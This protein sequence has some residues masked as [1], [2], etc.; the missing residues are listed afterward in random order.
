VPVTTLIDQSREMLAGNR[1]ASRLET[2]GFACLASHRKLRFVTWLAWAYQKLGLQ[3][4]FRRAS[5]RPRWSKWHRAEALLPPLSKP[6][7][8]ARRYR[9]LGATRG[10]VALFRGCVAATLDQDSLHACIELLTVSGFA[11]EVPADQTCCGA[12]QRHAGRAQTA[13][14]LIAVNRRAFSCKPADHIISL[15]TG[16]TLNLRQT[17]NS[18]PAQPLPQVH[19]A[20]ELLDTVVLSREAGVQFRPLRQRV[21]VH[22]PCTLRNGLSQGGAVSALLGRIPD[23]ELIALDSG[24]CCGAAGLHMLTHPEQ[25]DALREPVLRRIADCA[26]DVVVSSNVGCA[27]HL[28]AALRVRLPR[29]EVLHPVTLLWRQL[30]RR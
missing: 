3:H 13:R 4:L 1:P 21:L 2:V 14:E 8:T 26:P 10:K 5:L 11:V 15:A 19:D 7:P 6:K 12:V 18:T 25:A 29:L 27:M 16:C 22:L 30:D 9:S 24:G 20:C 17:L 28:A 23:I